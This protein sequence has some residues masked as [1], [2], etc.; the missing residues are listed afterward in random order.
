MCVVDHF[1]KD[2]PLFQARDKN[3]AKCANCKGAHPSWSKSCPQYTEAVQRSTRVSAAKVVSSSSTSKADLDA[4]VAKNKADLDTAK[5]TNR[6]EI[7]SAM[8]MLWQCL[9]NVLATAV[10]RSI[11]DLRAEEKRAAE[12]GTRVSTTEL[13]MRTA[14]STARAMNECRPLQVS[15]PIEAAEMQKTV[16]KSLFPQEEFPTASRA[17]SAPQDNDKT[18]SSVSQ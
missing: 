16:W 5:A 6:A 1:H 4:A 10:T 3:G 17:S 18:N 8:G 15:T 13:V 11:L 2:C 9:A 7:D 14:A 12:A